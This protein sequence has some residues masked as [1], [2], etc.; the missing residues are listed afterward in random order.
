MSIATAHGGSAVVGRHVLG[1]IVG[2]SDKWARSVITVALACGQAA[3][4]WSGHLASRRPSQIECDVARRDS[5]GEGGIRLE[6]AR[7]RHRAFQIMPLDI[8][9]KVV[10]SRHGA[11]E[12]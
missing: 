3:Q 7:Y 10:V 6:I 12:Q 1:S 4:P 2:T 11:G 8:L 5:V 9:P